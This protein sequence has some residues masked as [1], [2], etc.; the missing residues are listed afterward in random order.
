[1][2][3]AQRFSAGIELERGREPAKRGDRM[4]QNSEQ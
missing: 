4:L 3:V 1:M 2:I